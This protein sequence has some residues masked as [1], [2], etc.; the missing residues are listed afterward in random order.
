VSQQRGVKLSRL[1]KYNG[2]SED[3]KLSAGQKILLR[4]AKR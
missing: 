3:A 1:A 2:L 4:K